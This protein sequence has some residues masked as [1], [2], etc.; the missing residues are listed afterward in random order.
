MTQ[1]AGPGKVD[2][3]R[4]L[5]SVNEEQPGSMVFELVDTEQLWWRLLNE[6]Q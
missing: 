4:W 5:V 3:H 2:V 6:R 1:V